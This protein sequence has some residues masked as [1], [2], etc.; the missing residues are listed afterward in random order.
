MKPYF[1]RKPTSKISYLIFVLLSG[2]VELR[3]NTVGSKF[4]FKKA[5]DFLGVE[6]QAFAY[7]LGLWLADGYWRSSSIG[8]TSVNPKLIDKFSKFL[9]KVAPSHPLK[10][11][12]YEVK[13]GEKR[14][15]TAVQVYVN[16][17]PLTRL[18]MSTKTGDL[19]VSSKNLLAYLAGRIDGDGHVDTK[20]RSGIRIAYSSN[21]D[22]VRDQKMF[23]E[24][25]VRLY[26]YTQA[27]TYVLY[28]KKHFRER[29]SKEIKKFSLKLAP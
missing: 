29:I 6:P 23:G 12:I 4:S 5:I 24:T 18:F 26:Q 3:G 10:K 1:W 21:E 19:N 27:G 20:H 28:L 8:L 15:Q 7:I 17:R 25:N 9:L 13:K 22:A 11:R 16:N 14:K 2:N